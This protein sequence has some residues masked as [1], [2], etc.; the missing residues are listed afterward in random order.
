MV[1]LRGATYQATNSA[2]DPDAIHPEQ[3]T[4]SVPSGV[5]NHT[6]PALTIEVI[7]VRIQ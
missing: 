2:T 6:V 5:W 4:V 7:D 3:S 1:T